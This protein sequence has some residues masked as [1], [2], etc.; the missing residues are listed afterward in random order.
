MRHQIEARAPFLD[1]SVVEHAFALDAAALVPRVNGAPRGKAPLRALYDLY[2]DELPVSIRDRRKIPVNEGAGLDATQT[3]SQMK[4]YVEAQV[5]DAD[6][7]DGRDRFRD[8]DI[9]SKEELFYLD[10]LARMMDVERVPHLKGRLK[11]EVPTLGE[12][13]RLQEYVA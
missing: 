8:Y 12:D 4:H 6:Y 2:P 11:L 1:R 7:R 5:S 9:A 10:T 3:D 13:D